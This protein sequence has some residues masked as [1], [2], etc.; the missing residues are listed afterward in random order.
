MK[1]A[2][3]ILTLL[4]ALTFGPIVSADDWDKVRIGVE[5]AYPPFQLC[6]R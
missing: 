1:K 5:G 2:I 4:T 3:S 6:N